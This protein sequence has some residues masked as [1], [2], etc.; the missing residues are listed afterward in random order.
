MNRET[1]TGETGVTG[2]VEI[3]RNVRGTCR[4]TRLQLLHDESHSLTERNPREGSVSDRGAP[5]GAQSCYRREVGSLLC[6]QRE[7]I[8]ERYSN[9]ALSTRRSSFSI[10]FF[11]QSVRDERAAS[12]EIHYEFILLSMMSACECRLGVIGS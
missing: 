1:R 4:F 6:K 9:Y 8:V 5:S 3:Q 10:S 7:I 2:C 12:D 11:F